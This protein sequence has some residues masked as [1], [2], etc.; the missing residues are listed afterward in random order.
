[1]S[2]EKNESDI[3]LIYKIMPKVM[4]DIIPI[5]KDGRNEQQSYN[6]RGIDQIYNFI[7]PVFSKHGIWMKSEIL[8]V[9]RSERPSRSGGVMTFVQIRIRY[10]IVAPDGSSISTDV[11]GESMDSGD[12]AVPKALSVAQKYCLLQMFLIPTAE[13]KDVENDNPDPAPLPPA[14]KA[15][16]ADGPDDFFDE[17]P[18]PSP[19]D[20]LPDFSKAKKALGDDVYYRTLKVFG[21]AHANESPVEKRSEILKALRLQFKA[22]KT[23]TK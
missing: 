20:Q 17:P 3:G 19:F 12:K 9:Q 4:A 6:F 10:S 21:Y 23:G 5:G 22:V 13:A 14:P 18:A 16:H 1:M 7:Q 2:Q 8:D 11:L 15:S